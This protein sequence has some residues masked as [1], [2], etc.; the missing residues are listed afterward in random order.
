MLFAPEGAVLLNLQPDHLDRHGTFED[1]RAAK[2]RVFANQGNDDVAVAPVGLGVE[3]LGGCAR[4]VCFGAGRP[5]PRWPSA[6]GSCGG[7]TSR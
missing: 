2:L 1:Y 4:R 7:T 5:A 6:R 3:D